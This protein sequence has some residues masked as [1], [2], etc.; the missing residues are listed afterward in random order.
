MV[1]PMPST[2]MGVKY[3]MDT[4]GNM[5]VIMPDLI[6]IKAKHIRD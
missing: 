3:D 4:I 5:T 1:G 6:P 2:W